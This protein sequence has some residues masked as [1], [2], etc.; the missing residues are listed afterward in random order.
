MSQTA[1]Q[2]QRLVQQALGEFEQLMASDEKP[3]QVLRKMLETLLRTTAGTGAVAWMLKDPQ[4]PQMNIVA[5][6]GETASLVTD[7]DGN[8]LPPLVEALSQSTSQRKPIIVAPD[9]P[10][11]QKSDL[12][13][14]CQ[15]I[16]P[17][18][19][20]GRVLG[21][22]QL[23]HSRELD[24]KVYRQFVMFTQQAARAAGLYLARR[25][26]NV[27]REDL[28]TATRMLKLSHLLLKLRKP[29]EVTHEL[30]NLARGLIKA[31]RVSVVGYWRG[32]T[33]VQFSDVVQVN[34]KAVLVRAVEMLADVA[35]ERKVPMV[36]TK[37]QELEPEE[38][39]LLP[40]MEQLFELGSAEAA[41]V[42]PMM[43]GKHV[44]GVII[45]EF[46]D[47][48]EAS[49]RSAMQNE[50]AQQAGPI[51]EQ[52]V[53]WR[54]RPLRLFSDVLA[55]IRDRPFVAMLKTAIFAGII[56]AFV[57]FFFLVPV[58]MPVYGDA[59][60]DPAHLAQ[61][62][63]PEAG[64]VDEVFV[65]SGQI[66]KKGQ[67]VAQMDDMDLRLELGETEKRIDAYRVRVD[68]ARLEGKVADVRT[69]QLQIEQL[70][71]RKRSLER[72]IERAKIRS[73]IDGVVLD[74]RPERIQDMTKKEGD[75]LML[76][77]DLSS[78]ELV[79]EVEESDMALIEEEL[80]EG[81]EVPVAFLSK[82]WPDLVQETEVSRIEQISA[83]SKPNEYQTQH[84]YKV[85]VPIELQGMT[86][87]LVLANPT[88]RA[89]LDTPPRS[90][91]YRYGRGVWRFLQMTLFF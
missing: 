23:I 56:A 41:V 25:Q 30:A 61:L 14:A 80:R 45:S 1:D 2:V 59:R 48:S 57:W 54:Y 20:M 8:V 89:R 7:P 71:L 49:E 60:L 46:E 34:R 87:Q 51:L 24:P 13:G 40:L 74:D 16:V 52:A 12:H 63:M 3:S 18:D 31:Q 90:R 79:V 28:T 21:A 77:A 29:Q 43:S 9:Q 58:P 53:Q 75:V 76:V 15:F 66:V 44:V 19:A 6:V 69:A 32:K 88:G 36:F 62:T 84:V 26:A 35:R 22:I 65:K 10:D 42:T 85:I 78:F 81:G 4:N 37:G 47:A 5:Q 82:P 64:R 11:F 55:A 17:V 68:A 72:R 33:D 27:L 70:E 50:L 67:V 38:E 86:P 91:A 83:T 39:A 73:L